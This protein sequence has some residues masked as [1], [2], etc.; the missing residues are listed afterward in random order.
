MPP[1]LQ[2]WPL[3]LPGPSA[4]QAQHSAGR[5][6]L[7]ECVRQTVLAGPGHVDGSPPP[8]SLHKQMFLVAPVSRLEHANGLPARLQMLRLPLGPSPEPSLVEPGP[9]EPGHKHSGALVDWPAAVPLQAT[10]SL[11]QLVLHEVT[12]LPLVAQF[13]P[14]CVE[15]A[16]LEQKISPHWTQLA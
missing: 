11:P 16:Q 10:V 14:V 7:F 6:A 15:L 3:V 5:C 8:A 12:Q 4:V 2:F 13:D 1:P 9:F